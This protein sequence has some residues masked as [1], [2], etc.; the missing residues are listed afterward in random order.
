MCLK[1]GF[2]SECLLVFQLEFSGLIHSYAYDESIDDFVHR[3]NSVLLPAL[4][5]QIVNVKLNFFDCITL[6]EL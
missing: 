5:L 2:S 3:S 6:N 1:T 4:Y